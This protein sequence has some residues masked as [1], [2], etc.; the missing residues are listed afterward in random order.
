MHEHIKKNIKK[1]NK[2]II[3]TIICDNGLWW[4]EKKKKWNG[5]SGKGDILMWEKKMTHVLVNMWY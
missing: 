5:T 4:P 3:K 1:K 2:K